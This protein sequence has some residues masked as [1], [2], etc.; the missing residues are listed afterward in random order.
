MDF[1]KVGS[2]WLVGILLS[3]TKHGGDEVVDSPCHMSSEFLLLTKSREDS[4]CFL[5]PLICVRLIALSSFIVVRGWT[6]DATRIDL[7]VLVTSFWLEDVHLQMRL[8][9]SHVVYLVLV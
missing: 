1:L 9:L 3:L 7:L 5:I 8:L 4:S 6:D 2:L